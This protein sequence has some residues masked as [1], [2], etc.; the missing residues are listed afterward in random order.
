MRPRSPKR[1][2]LS[3]IHVM[4]PIR[5]HSSRNRNFAID[6]HDTAPIY[7]ASN[8]KNALG[9]CLQ[10]CEGKMRWSQHTKQLTIPI[11]VFAPNKSRKVDS[12]Y[13]LSSFL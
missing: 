1:L 7:A 13:I 12:A 11:A 6:L 4:F 2:A 8:R 9:I 5:F 10:E 3:Q